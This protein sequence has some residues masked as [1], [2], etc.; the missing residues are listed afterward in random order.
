MKTTQVRVKLINILFLTLLA[1][2]V[3]SGQ[4]SIGIIEVFH[5]DLPPSLETLD[6][7]NA[8][9]ARFVDDYEISYNLITDSATV[10]LIRKY[11]LPDT[12]FPFA[13]VIDGC[14]SAMIDGEQ[15]DFV[16]FPLFM[17]GIGRHEGNWSMEYLELVLNDNTLLMDESI[18]PVLDEEGDTPCQG[19][20]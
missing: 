5:K 12:H 4:A 15:I 19:E 2:S 9:L 11:S 13:V 18:L 20:E 8:V 14:Y 10:D 16:H 3:S 7:T 6:R 17:H 1:L